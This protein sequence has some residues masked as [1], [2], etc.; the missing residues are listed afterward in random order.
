MKRIAA[1]IG[2][3]LFILI[4]S[5]SQA[6][7]IDLNRKGS[8]TISFQDEDGK[9]IPK[10]GTVAVYQVAK[11][12]NISGHITFALTNEFSG[13]RLDPTH[14]DPDAAPAVIMSYISHHKKTCAPV[15]TAA[16]DAVVSFK[17][18]PCGLYFVEQAEIPKNYRYYQMAE[19]MA[20]IPME[21]ADGLVYNVKAQPKMELDKNPQ[22][23]PTPP[24][25][26][27]PQTG[28]DTTPM[29]ILFSLGLLLI[30]AGFVLLLMKKRQ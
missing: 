20:F 10:N 15:Q 14:M 8:I 7:D 30:I 28:T 18:L 1:L 23:T 16:A 9:P 21:T 17:N 11:A 24:G 13:I 27:L 5:T 2:S 26:N 25:G 3:L 29:T 22:P 4:F 6:Q 19:F 12:E